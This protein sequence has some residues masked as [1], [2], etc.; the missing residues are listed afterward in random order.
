M[1]N[2]EITKWGGVRQYSSP[3]A[4][5]IELMAENC[6]LEGSNVLQNVITNDLIDEG[7]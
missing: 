6:I 2:T 5:A 4:E 3:L 1:K 7:V